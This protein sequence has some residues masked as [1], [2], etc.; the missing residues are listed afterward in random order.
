MSLK[1]ELRMPNMERLF[2]HVRENAKH[3]KHWVDP[4][5]HTGKSVTICGAGPSLNAHL[6]ELTDTD[7]TWACNGALPYLLGKGVKATHGFCVDQGDEMMG[8]QEWGKIRDVPCYVASSIHPSLAEHLAKNATP[9]WF[10]NFL[11]IDKP[12]ET[13][14]VELYRTLYPRTV[15]A[16]LGLNAAAR[17]V[18][19]ALGMGFTDIRVYGADSAAEPDQPEMPELL[20]SAYHDWMR[21]LVMYADGRTA[22]Q[23]YG[24]DSPMAE[25]PE[26]DGRRWVT[27][28]DMIISAIHLIR[29]AEAYAPR[30]SLMGDSMLTAIAKQPEEWWTDLPVLRAD[31]VIE[32]FGTKTLTPTQTPQTPTTPTPTLKEQAAA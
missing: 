30:V 18:C 10:H 27:R 23:V 5:S 7:E 26:I 11:G 16:G 32:G 29:I 20:T 28:P 31:G 21:H 15:V 24:V 22:A 19:L 14:E 17:A 1:C 25:A 13:I 8:E 3:V 4:F 2:D 12:G 9:I 6:S